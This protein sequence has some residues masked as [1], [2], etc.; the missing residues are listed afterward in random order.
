MSDYGDGLKDGRLLEADRLKAENKSLKELL[1]SQVKANCGIATK[2][3]EVEESRDELLEFVKD[4]K[5][6]K[7]SLWCEEGTETLKRVNGLIKKSEQ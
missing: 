6:G 1:D 5:A 2:L 4:W 7:I 3:C